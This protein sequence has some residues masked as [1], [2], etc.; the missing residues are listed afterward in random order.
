[1][2]FLIGPKRYDAPWKDIE[3]Q[4]HSTR[5]PHRGPG[6]AQRSRADGVRGRRAGPEIPA[7]IHRG[8]QTGVV[9]DLVLKHRGTPTLVIGQY[10]DQLED[11][12]A[13]LEAPLITGETTVR[14]R[15]QLY[16]AFRSGEIDLLVE[17]GG[18]LDRPAVRSD[19]RP[20]IGCLRLSAG[21]GA[22]ARP[23]ATTQVGGS[24]RAS[25]RRGR[26]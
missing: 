11:L 5:R 21:G 6:H 26:S 3:A 20:G 2:S 13:R 4:L 7:R 10:V 22:A 12:A 14:R 1:M 8:I 15:E 24:H 17:Q 16:E 9:V 25:L 18:K 23:V 19:R